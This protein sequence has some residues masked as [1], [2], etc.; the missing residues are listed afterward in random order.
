MSITSK[1]RRDM[2]R[3]RNAESRARR[4]YRRYLA[5]RHSNTIKPA[6]A[7][8][9]PPAYQPVSLPLPGERRARSTWWS[10]PTWV[11][12]AGAMTGSLAAIAWAALEK[13]GYL[14]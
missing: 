12:V 1:A 10:W 5:A 11:S 9:V 14:V 4:A 3:R 13:A 8:E 6:T 2:R 7:R